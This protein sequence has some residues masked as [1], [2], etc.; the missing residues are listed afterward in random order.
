[1]SLLWKRC[2]LFHKEH[3]L[4]SETRTMELHPLHKVPEYLE[5]CVD[6]LNKQW[7]RSREARLNSLAK[8]NDDFPQSLVLIHSAARQLVGHARLCPMP[9]YPTYCLIESVIIEPTMR[10]CGRGRFLMDAC[11]QFAAQRGYCYMYLSTRECQG[12]YSRCGYKCCKPLLTVGSS[13]MLFND[14]RVKFLLSKSA[15]QQQQQQKCVAKVRTIRGAPCNSPGPI[16]F[17]MQ[18]KISVIP[19]FPVSMVKRISEDVASS[20]TFGKQERNGRLT[21]ILAFACLKKTGDRLQNFEKNKMVARLLGAPLKKS[22][23]VDLGGPLRSYIASSYSTEDCPTDS[24][25]VNEFCRLRNKACCVQHDKQEGSLEIL[26]RYYDQL[27]ALEG[28]LPLTPSQIPVPFK[29][30]EA[31]ERSLFGKA[32]LT[33]C[34]GS[35]EKACV[36][37]NIASLQ[38]Q[39][40]AA[41]RFD[42]DDELKL[43]T[44]LF[45]QSASIYAY[46]KDNIMAMVQQEPTADLMPETLQTLSMFMLA[47]AQE[48]FFLKASKDPL[49]LQELLLSVLP[50]TTKRIKCF[51]EKEWIP[52]SGGKCFA[53]QALAQYYQSLMAKESKDVGEE[54]A[55][56]QYA[57]ELMVM[58]QE[59]L[60]GQNAQLFH[61]ESDIIHKAYLA[62]K[63]DND[64]IYHEKIPNIKS[65]P[66]ISK[67]V[68]A[69][70]SPLPSQ[71]SSKFHD[72]FEKLVPIN[73]Q[74]AVAC[75]EVRRAELVNKEVGRLREH[76]NM[77]NGLLA[78][79]NLPTALEDVSKAEP[80]PESIR[81]KSIKVKSLGGV[82]GLKKSVDELPL[83]YQRNKEILDETKRLLNEERASD[84]QLRSQ[85]KEKW[86]RMPSEKLTEPLW[87]EITK[88]QNVLDAAKNAD[89]IVQQGLSQHFEGIE[90][91][92]K[93]ETDLRASIPGL[94]R[95]ASMRQSAVVLKLQEMMNQVTELKRDREEIEKEFENA[96]LEMTPIFLRAFAESSIVVEEAVSKK[97]LDETFSPI[98]TLV[99]ESIQAQEKLTDAILNANE[100][101][102][103]E[104]GADSSIDRDNMLRMLANAHDAFLELHAN[105][106]EGTK[107]YNDMTPLIVRLQ[108]KI[109][110]FCFARK[111]EKD[112]LM[113]DVQ[114]SII[115]QPSGNVPANPSFESTDGSKSRRP[116]R[117][118]PPAVPSEEQQATL[119]QM[120]GLTASA[121]YMMGTSP[122]AQQLTL[123]RFMPYPFAP[124]TFSP[125]HYY[126]TYPGGGQQP[127]YPTTI[128]YPMPANV[129]TCGLSGAEGVPVPPLRLNKIIKASNNCKEG[130][131]K[132]CDG[133]ALFYTPAFFV[134][135]TS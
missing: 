16:P 6:L 114:Q 111:T 74:Q 57:D 88:F 59:K 116:P 72:L 89:S 119:R 93:T 71:M 60:T 81:E 131:T 52:L 34:S 56:L 118:P 1:M 68:L 25:A 11:E 107:F 61:N 104:K 8:S 18:C 41:Q 101:F 5:A 24:A 65:V 7:P 103:R 45:Q 69:K 35:Y 22:Y 2:L 124:T 99:T 43:A 128:N 70:T 64:F 105:V 67:T 63:K 113:R 127:P 79:L 80:L 32:S 36:L 29:W 97:H 121:P 110:D 132:D 108:Q 4:L 38:S 33:I 98:Q 84:E 26:Y 58:A 20:A 82:A 14:E 66:P 40:A 19:C 112:D 106:K 55:R 49:L 115:N 48:A 21:V 76:T 125:G 96:K 12:F 133:V 42:A 28:K 86:T 10:N 51:P 123:Q 85:F 13:G 44:K 73:V 91:L 27:V 46:L 9:Q 94:A 3:K 50:C 126:A 15:Q 117:P 31:F 87:Q 39:V 129:S 54:L 77:L 78:S 17:T 62:A 95:S 134:V 30:K 122:G 109:S 120:P 37:F 130:V 102:V 90:K 83:L 135:F 100:Q 53:F 92:S 75:F 23:E 47:Q